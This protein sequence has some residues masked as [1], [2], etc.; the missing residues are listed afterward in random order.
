MF[1]NKTVELRRVVVTGMG[2]ISPLGNDVPTAWRRLL[3]G[4]SGI[5][6]T[7]HFAQNVAE[8]QERFRAPDDFPLIA[9]EVKDF[10]IKTI[11]RQRKKNQTRED[12]KLI[13]YTDHFTQY[14][15]AASL[16]AVNNS[17]LALEQENPDR[18]GIIIAS[19]MGGV[20]SWEEQHENL[21]TQGVKKVSPFTVPKLLP[22]LAAG[23]VSISFQARGPN[24]ALSTA[25]AA[26]AHAIGSAFRSIQLGEAELMATGGAEA[27]I[28]PLTVTGFYRMG[29]L[30]TGYND[31]P[32]LAS[33]PFDRQHQGFVMA[34]GAGILILE[35]L[36]HAR[37]RNARILA[38]LIGFSTTGDARHITDPDINGAVR[39]MHMALQDAGLTPAQ[40]DY[41]N[42]HATSTP[43]G[44]RNEAAALIQCFS[45]CQRMPLVSATKSM[46]GHMLGAAGAVEAIFVILSLS[47]GLIPPTI[48]VDEIDPECVGLNLVRN[49]ALEIP[50]RYALSNSFGF[51]GTNASLV[52]KRYEV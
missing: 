34:E 47:Q 25:C 42:P 49:K 17:G 31:R 7:T 24:A 16:E 27:A 29:A 44:D 51:G 41:V 18:V 1:T 30:A 46:T 35:E 5:G 45:S 22:N 8:F 12:N 15:L 32:T 10:E 3:A 4:E 2:L 6:P 28:T 20:G 38:E 52:F 14:A 23:N 9:G 13:K 43:T 37:R 33:R 11:L 26:G 36:E 21:L 50:L 48:N 39:C 19:G 40:I